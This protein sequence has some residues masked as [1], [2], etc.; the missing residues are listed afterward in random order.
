MEN[1]VDPDVMGDENSSYL[2]CIMEI[3]H[4]LNHNQLQS[5]LLIYG[6]V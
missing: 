3:R 5:D 6:D 4:I 2:V 1:S